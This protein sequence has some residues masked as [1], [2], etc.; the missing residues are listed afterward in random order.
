MK[1]RRLARA[2]RIHRAQAIGHLHFLWWWALDN[3]PTG[4]L[5]ALAPAEIAEVAEWTGDSEAFVQAL[6]ECRWLDPDGQIHDWDEY[7]GR[8]IGDRKADRERKRLARQA[9]GTTHGQPQ[10]TPSNASGCPPDVHR[11]STGH[12]AYPTQPN[13]TVPNPTQPEPPPNSPPRSDTTRTNAAQRKP[14]SEREAVECGVMLG[15]SEADAKAWHA[16]MEATGWAKID[17]T[18]FGNWRREMSVHRDRLRERGAGLAP[19]QRSGTP[20]LHAPGPSAFTLKTQLE[21]LDREIKAITDRGHEDAHGWYPK[22]EDDRSKYIELKKKRKA[23]NAQL[24]GVT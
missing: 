16:D 21:A 8:L 5:S 15:L 11:T 18:P 2:L 4:N 19:Q 3:A 22:D 23:V 9:K 1:L 13:P 14:A 6:K 12:P 10:D 7:A 24:A 17:G 20:A